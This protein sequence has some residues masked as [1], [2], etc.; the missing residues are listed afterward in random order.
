[1]ETKRWD[2]FRVLPPEQDSGSETNQKCLAITVRVLKVIAYILT[3]ALVLGGTVVSKGTFFFMTSQVRKGRTVDYCN[4]DIGRDKTFRA[5]LPAQEQ[6]A[7]VWAIFIAFILPELGTLF[8]SLRIV[9]F[10][11]CRRP[12]VSDFMTGKK[13]WPGTEGGK[14]DREEEREDCSAAKSGSFVPSFVRRQTAS[15]ER[16]KRS[17]S[18]PRSRRSASLF[19]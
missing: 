9:T 17:S 13:L 10:K 19:S 7:W 14:A 1:M 12:S 5:E 6:T 16:R 11:S 3:F 4:H 2:V 18:L 8:R 15:G